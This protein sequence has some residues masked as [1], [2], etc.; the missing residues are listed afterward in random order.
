MK[1]VLLLALC[2]M[3][4]TACDKTIHEARLKLDQPITRSSVSH[5]GLTYS[6]PNN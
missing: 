6:A 4:L 1:Y 2:T 3:G 5:S